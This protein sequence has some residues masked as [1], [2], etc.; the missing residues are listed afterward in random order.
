MYDFPYVDQDDCWLTSRLVRVTNIQEFC[1]GSR[2]FESGGAKCQ[3]FSLPDFYLPQ[4]HVTCP[5]ISY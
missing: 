2:G 5:R 4:P 3:L 1:L